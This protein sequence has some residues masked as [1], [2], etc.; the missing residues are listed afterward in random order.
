MRMDMKT[1]MNE[2]GR[3]YIMM[4]MRRSNGDGVFGPEVFG[5]KISGLGSMKRRLRGA[6]SD[7]R[8]WIWRSIAM[9]E[10]LLR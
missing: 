7:D 6:D 2:V 8:A 1:R 5:R 10:A 4:T 3:A 9:Q